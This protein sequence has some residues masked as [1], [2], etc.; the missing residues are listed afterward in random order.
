M[1]AK[2]AYELLAFHKL[3]IV[4]YACKFFKQKWLIS[5]VTVKK[6]EGS[7]FQKLAKF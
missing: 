6:D 3:P 4:D 5:E 2:N 7:R 1:T